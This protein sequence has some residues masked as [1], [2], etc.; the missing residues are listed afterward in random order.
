MLL[1]ASNPKA[2]AK[3]L[4]AYK[5]VLGAISLSGLVL[6]GVATSSRHKGSQL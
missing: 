5:N 4:E 6:Q 1:Q 3:K 2:R